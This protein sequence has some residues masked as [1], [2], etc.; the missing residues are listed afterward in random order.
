[1]TL[2]SKSLLLV[3]HVYTK[4][5]TFTVS[6][7][8]TDEYGHVSA[9]ATATIEVVPVALE[10]DPFNSGQSAL[11]VGSSGNATVTFAAS[12]KGI[13]VTL[14]GLNEGVFNT[15]GPLILFAQGGKD[16]V[17][18]GSGLKNSLYLPESPTADNVETD[19][20]NETMRWAGLTAAVEI[21]NV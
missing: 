3:S 2:S 6:V 14:G 18:E 15:S 20:D 17:K 11:F 16:T 7:T 12:G 5:G 10:T 13:D 9:A 21:L 8:A 4:T 19:L 1:V